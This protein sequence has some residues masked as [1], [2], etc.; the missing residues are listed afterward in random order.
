MRAVRPRT[1][2]NSIPTDRSKPSKASPARADVSSARWATPNVPAPTS[3]RTSPATSTSPSSKAGSITSRK[4]AYAKGRGST[5]CCPSLPL[6]RIRCLSGRDSTTCCPFPMVG[7]ALRARRFYFF[8]NC[9][10]TVV[11]C[12]I[13]GRR[14][15][16]QVGGVL[17]GLHFLIFVSSLFVKSL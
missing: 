11:P 1:A 5:A 3:P 10:N 9:P 15:W 13:W 7:R 14:A 6:H 2:S 12:F 8:A 17:T 4:P 16:I